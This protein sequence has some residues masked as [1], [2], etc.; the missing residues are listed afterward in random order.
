MGDLYLDEDVS[1]DTGR[2][3]ISLG[4]DALDA[5]GVLEHATKVHQHLA[6]ATRLGRVLVTHNAADYLLV[7]LAWRE[8]FE[9]FVESPRPEH[10]G[11]LLLPQ[12]PELGAIEIADLV[13]AFV[14]ER[15][16][17]ELRNRLFQWSK[18]GGWLEIVPTPPRVL[19]PDAPRR[20]F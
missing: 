16:M 12:P 9:E 5:R 17:A 2:R 14:A 8:W 4:D 1:G 7:H 13:H 18:R 11:I 6:M 19:P 20:R 3:L 10:A 15:T